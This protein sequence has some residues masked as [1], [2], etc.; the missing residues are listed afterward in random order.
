MNQKAPQSVGA[1]FPSSGSEGSK[2]KQFCFPL[3]PFVSAYF[4]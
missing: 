2:G 1:A 3:F 4:R